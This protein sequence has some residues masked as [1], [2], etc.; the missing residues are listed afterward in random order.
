MTRLRLDNVAEGIVSNPDK[1]NVLNNG[2]NS[3]RRAKLEKGLKRTEVDAIR[4]FTSTLTGFIMCE[5]GPEKTALLAELRKLKK[6]LPDR[7]VDIDDGTNPGLG[8]F[9]ESSRLK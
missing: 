3:F 4:R 1:E 6:Y 5:E 7:P 8:K 2:L 9:F